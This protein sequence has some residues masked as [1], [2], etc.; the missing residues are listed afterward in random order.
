MDKKKYSKPEMKVVLL[1]HR[2]SLLAGSDT[3]SGDGTGTGSY[4]PGMDNEDMN[5]LA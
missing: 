3:P 4:I 1:K 2:P 5:K